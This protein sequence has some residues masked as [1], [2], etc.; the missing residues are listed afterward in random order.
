MTRVFTI[1]YVK[2]GY[3]FTYM[4]GRSR[5]ICPLWVRPLLIL[6][7]PSV[8]Y[9]VNAVADSFSDGLKQAFRDEKRSEE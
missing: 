3:K 7:S 8:Y 2:K 1:W 9:Y 5:W 4:D 6:F